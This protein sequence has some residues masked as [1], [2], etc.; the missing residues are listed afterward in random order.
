MAIP[1]SLDHLVDYAYPDSLWVGYERHSEWAYTLWVLDLDFSYNEYLACK[2][3]NDRWTLSPRSVREYDYE[4][5][6]HANRVE[7]SSRARKTQQTPGSTTIK[8]ATRGSTA[9]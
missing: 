8:T 6:L 4:T 3:L 5:Q 1:E 7:E 9:S 2:S